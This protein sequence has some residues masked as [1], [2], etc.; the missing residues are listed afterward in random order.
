VQLDLSID[1]V[2][3]LSPTQAIAGNNPS[4]RRSHRP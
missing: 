3:W 1:K 2:R 4:W